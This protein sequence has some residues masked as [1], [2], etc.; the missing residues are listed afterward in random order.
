MGMRFRKSIK[1]SKATRIN[2]SKSGVGFSTGVKGYRESIGPSGVRTTATLPGT[3]IGYETRTGYKR[4]SEDSQIIGNIPIRLTVGGITVLLAVILY[5]VIG[6]VLDTG[7]KKEEAKKAAEA[8]AYAQDQRVQDIQ[9]RVDELPLDAG[10]L[11][12]T[13]QSHASIDRKTDILTLSVSLG[14]YNF[15]END[16][17]ESS[18]IYKNGI[19][20]C[21]YGAAVLKEID[22]LKMDFVFI[23]SE[24]MYS[25]DIDAPGTQSFEELL[26]L[27]CILS[28]LN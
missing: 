5:F 9:R 25:C 19:I 27:P 16:M 23:N 12:G 10:I 2:L 26:S 20:D 3:G 1:I 28:E 13:V 17:A 18:L 8:I 24:I 22:R 15:T 4:K 21:L 7:W 6:N 11:F 14:T